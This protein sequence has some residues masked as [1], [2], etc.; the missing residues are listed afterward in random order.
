VDY[1]HHRIETIVIITY[2]INLLGLERE[3][4]EERE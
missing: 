2:S 1:H 3:E 4:E